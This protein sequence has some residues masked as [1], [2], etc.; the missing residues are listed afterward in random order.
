MDRKNKEGNSYTF[1]DDG[2]DY[3]AKLADGGMRD[4][5]T[6]MDKCLAYSTELTVENVVK[7]LGTTDYD[8]MFKLTAALLDGNAKFVISIIEGIH[9]DGK[10]LKQFVK[11]YMQFL[12]DVNKYVIGCDWKYINI[13]KLEDY[14]KWMRE[15]S[16][17]DYFQNFVRRL[18]SVVINLNADIKYST[19]PKYD[20]EAILIQECMEDVE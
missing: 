19:T 5:I 13:P 20:I 15:S 14:E 17:I 6:M 4:A 2:L 9:S 3:I 10:D 8:T 11:L 1:D 16:E 18:L 12:L 7:A